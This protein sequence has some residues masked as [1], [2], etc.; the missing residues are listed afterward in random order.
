MFL[1]I[2]NWDDAVAFHAGVYYWGT[3]TLIVFFALSFVLVPPRAK[4]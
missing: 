3:I 4:R 1:G 2:L